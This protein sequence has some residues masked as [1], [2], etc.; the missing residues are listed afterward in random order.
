MTL[1]EFL[2]TV[3]AGKYYVV[4]AVLLVLGGTFLYLDRQDT[5]FESTATV[6]VAG[7]DAVP[8]AETG[9]SVSVDADPEQVHEPAVVDAAAEQLDEDPTVLVG[10][11]SGSYDAETQTLSVTAQGSTAEQAVGR[12]N[13]VAEAY[14]AFMPTVLEEQLA[15]LDDRRQA[16]REQLAPVRR[17]LRGSA[18]DPLATAE[19]DTIVEQYRAV[20]AL[21]SSFQSISEPAVLDAP[22]TSAVPQGLPPA[23]VAALG[24]LVGLVAGVGLAFARRG[25]DL[26]VRTP[27]EA[28]RLAEVPVLAGL[29]DVRATAKE[30]RRTGHLPVTSRHASPFTESV[31]ELR[32]AVRVSLGDVR[33]AIVVVTAADPHAPR[34]FITAN[35][36]ASFALSGRSTLLLSGD[37]RRPEVE[38]TV[39]E[40]EHPADTSERIRPTHIPNLRLVSI[41]NEAMDPADY[42]A[43]AEVRS[44]LEELREEAAI[45]VVD[46]PPVLAAADATILGGYADGV[47]LIAS[48]ERTD[49]VVL[50]EAAGRLRI[51]H[52]PLVGLALS[53][54]KGDRR[55]RYASSYGTDA[56][57]AADSPS[58][59][60]AESADETAGGDEGGAWA[61]S[62]DDSGAAR[63]EPAD[64]GAASADDPDRSRAASVP[65]RDRMSSDHPSMW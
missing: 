18:D 47:V 24:V 58:E 27:G 44:L 33:Q 55:M 29:H 30:F 6:T 8:G 42:L 31:R 2:Q 17:E 1:R 22:A 14:V 36:A 25:L 15:A 62:G 64:S 11:T 9:T 53:G 40:G 50:Q 52:V 54:V 41:H 28:A 39:G 61:T 5:V 4:A 7:T 46:A 20:S 65:G 45:I 26:R 19:Q 37:L 49:R 12:A 35:L 32:T 56:P 60:P 23:L 48:L 10:A 59:G 63:D 13:A 3:W 16:L 34:A 57:V 21:H 43:T 51:N 38:E